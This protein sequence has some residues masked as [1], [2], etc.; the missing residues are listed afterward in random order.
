MNHL[1]TAVSWWRGLRHNP[2]YLR[3]KGSWGEPNTLYITLR[4]YSPLVLA[5]V[6]VGGICSGG[7]NQAWLVSNDALFAL[8]CLVCIPGLLLTIISLYGV[9]MAPVMTAPLISMERDRGTW[10]II[11]A[12]PQSTRSI[13][14]SKMFGGL[15]RLRIWPWL[16]IL[17][18]VQGS[19]LIL[20]IFLVGDSMRL[21]G[22]PL[23]AFA[24][25]RPWVEI[26]FAG[27]A[28]MLA[29]LWLRSAMTALISAYTAV[30]FIKALNSSTLWLL[31]SLE[32]DRLDS[33]APLIWSTIGPTAVYMLLCLVLFSILLWRADR[34]S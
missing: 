28:G 31:I 4:R 15:A 34:M 10:D 30:F 20:S 2:I 1:A 8:A 33:N 16:F 5:G 6:I 24:F 13:V 23:G 32:I 26:F 18:A 27:L 19:I 9:F 17:S 22:I 29:S 11:R 14:L 12:T 7:T 25:L 3:E 21:W